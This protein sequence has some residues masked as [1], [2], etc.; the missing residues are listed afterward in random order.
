MFYLF[1]FYWKGCVLNFEWIMGIVYVC[2]IYF[3]MEFMFC[4]EIWICISI[5]VY[6]GMVCM[7]IW[8]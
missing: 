1:D 4:I 7:Y 2:I 3:F 8:I 6:Y 5:F